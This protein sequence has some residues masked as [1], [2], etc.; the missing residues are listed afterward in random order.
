MSGLRFKVGSATRLSRGA[1]I[2]AAVLLVVLVLAPWWAEDSDM[3]S[4]AEFAYLVAIAQMWN[5]LAGY[6]GLI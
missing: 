3:R 1:W 5:L 6:G 4:I 2:A